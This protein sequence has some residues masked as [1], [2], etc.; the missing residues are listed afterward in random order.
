MSMK[1]PVFGQARWL[2]P[3]IPAHWEAEAGGSRG[4]EIET[5]LVNM[6]ESSSVIQARVQWCYLGSLQSPPLGFKKFS[7][8]SLLRS[9][10]VTQAGVQW[11]NHSSLAHYS[12]DL[13]GSS[14]PP[15]LA[16]R[17]AETT[18]THHHIQLIFC[19]D[20]YFGKP[21]GA[22]HQRSRIQDQ[23]GQ[24][25]ETPSLLKTQI[26]DGRRSHSVTQA[27]VRWHSLC[28]L[29]FLDTS[30]PPTSAS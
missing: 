16:S 12:L 10:S 2:T 23:T 4:Q 27:G 25:G 3:I 17:R 7:C 28:S 18:D 19:K 14:D 20:Q 11:C 6:T 26:S 21:R 30:K 8:L 13:P 9:H 22:D 1:S 5:I 29:D 15:T 24:H